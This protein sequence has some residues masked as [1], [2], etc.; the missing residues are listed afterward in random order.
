MEEIKDPN[1][2]RDMSDAEEVP[3][4][5]RRRWAAAA[6]AEQSRGRSTENTHTAPHT[7]IYW[8]MRDYDEGWGD[9]IQARFGGNMQWRLKRLDELDKGWDGM[10]ETTQEFGTLVGSRSNNSKMY[11]LTEQELA[12]FWWDQDVE[13]QND[14]ASGRTVSFLEEIAVMPHPIMAQIRTNRGTDEFKEGGGTYTGQ[15]AADWREFQGSKKAAEDAADAADAGLRALY[16][17]NMPNYS[18]FLSVKR[19]Q[20]ISSLKEAFE[21]AQVGEAL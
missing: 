3:K 6:A 15:M 13:S 21:G 7:K 10:M 9:S 19:E 2:S 4:E 1:C 14:M 16:K 17:K 18:S 8:G 12:A 5:E 11:R 20:E